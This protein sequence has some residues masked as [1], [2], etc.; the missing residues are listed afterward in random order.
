[1]CSSSV[2]HS[3]D[4]KHAQQIVVVC[5]VKNSGKTTLLVRIVEK[6]T[7]IGKKVAVIKHDGHDF[8][9]D[10][11]ETDSFRLKAAGAYGTA[12]YSKYRMFIHK[13]DTEPKLSEMIRQFPEAEIILIEG[14]KASTFPK[15]EVIRKG[16]SEYPISNPVGRFL[17]VTDRD[18]EAYAEPAVGFEELDEI[19]KAILNVEDER[20]ITVKY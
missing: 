11:P 2:N 15:I 5:G 16:V 7:Q 10:I 3:E 8:T 1:M 9:C 13:T 12:V 14:E 20:C 6:L 17:I 19:V 4:K 18:K